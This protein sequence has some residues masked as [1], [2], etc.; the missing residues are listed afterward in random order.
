MRSTKGSCKPIYIS[1]GHRVSLNTAI[2]IVKMICK[3]RVPE[4]IRQVKPCKFKALKVSLTSG[5]FSMKDLV[6]VFRQNRQ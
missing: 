2:H 3:Y 5:I 6:V 1:V 4:P